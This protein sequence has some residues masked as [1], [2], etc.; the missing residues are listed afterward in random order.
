MTLTDLTVKFLRPSSGDFL[1][2]VELI[3]VTNEIELERLLTKVDSTFVVN[4]VN[5]D[6]GVQVHQVAQL[7]SER[8]HQGT[9]TSNEQLFGGVVDAEADYRNQWIWHIKVIIKLFL[10]VSPQLQGSQNVMPKGRWLKNPPSSAWRPY[11]SLPQPGIALLY[12]GRAKP[13]PTTLKKLKISF[14]FWILSV[15]EHVLERSELAIDLLFVRS[16]VL[17]G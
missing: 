12:L 8:S 4:F 1:V 9:I 7:L 5:A 11:E 14:I 3:Q 16:E 13:I 6:C 15:E 2:S 17:D 10:H